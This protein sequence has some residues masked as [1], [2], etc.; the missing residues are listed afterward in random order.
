MTEPIRIPNI[1]NY[2]QEIVNGE[3]ILIPK[4]KVK[5]TLYEI[6]VDRLI[7]EFNL[8]GQM[9]IIKNLEKNIREDYNNEQKR[10]EMYEAEICEW[11]SGTDRTLETDNKREWLKKL[12]GISYKKMEDIKRKNIVI[13]NLK[14]NLKMT[15]LEEFIE[16]AIDLELI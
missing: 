16:S 12:V 15:E 10:C 2:T 5:K 4:K 9:F 11:T 3:L 8:E 7:N 14:Y 6:L 1:E 13:K